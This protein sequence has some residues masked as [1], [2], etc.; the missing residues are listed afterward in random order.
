MCMYIYV[1][2]YVYMHI[3]I[4]VHVYVSSMGSSNVCKRLD[5]EDD[6]YLI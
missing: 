5:D 1:Y 2:V 6:V 4:F 3:R